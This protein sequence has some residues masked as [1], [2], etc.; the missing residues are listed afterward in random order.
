M[1]DGKIGFLTNHADHLQLLV[2]A[3]SR[4]IS[5]PMRLKT[6]IG[7]SAERS[8]R[9]EGENL[10]RRIMKII[11]EGRVDTNKVNKLVDRDFDAYIDSQLWILTEAHYRHQRHL[12]LLNLPRAQSQR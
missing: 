9:I 6:S 11:T 7:I 10:A 2:E 8:W 1:L 4:G 12:N 3:P 5:T